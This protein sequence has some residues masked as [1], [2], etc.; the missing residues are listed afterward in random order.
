MVAFTIILLFIMLLLNFTVDCE[1]EYEQFGECSKSC[2]EGIKTRYPRITVQPQHGGQDC[3]LFVQNQEPDTTTCNNSPCPGLNQMYSACDTVK[4]YKS[5]LRH[6]LLTLCS[7]TYSWVWCDRSTH[8]STLI[9]SYN[10]SLQCIVSGSM[11]N[12]GSAARH[13]AEALRHDSQ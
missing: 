7:K 2:G 8:S 1:W 12:M 9:M 11:V 4:T 6:V 10:Y 13:V 5:L 3:P